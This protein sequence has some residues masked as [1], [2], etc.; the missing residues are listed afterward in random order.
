MQKQEAIKRLEILEK[1]YNL[2]P[3]VLKEFTKDGTLY[4]SEHISKV[5]SGIL[6]WLSNEQKYV[7]AVKEVEDKYN[8]YVYHII[9]NHTECGDWLTMLFISGDTEMW[10][11]DLEDL[12]TTRVFAYVETFDENS[13]FGYVEITGVNGGI[14]RVA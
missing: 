11:Y 2:H 6:Y 1:S 3:N 13:E 7:D 4:Y 10:K 12:E 8:I 5:Q 9:L 14:D